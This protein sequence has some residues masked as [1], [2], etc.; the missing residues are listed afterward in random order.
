M[1]QDPLEYRTVP[2]TPSP[3]HLGCSF[4]RGEVL[5]IQE[6]LQAQEPP[7]YNVAFPR[8][9]VT[10]ALRTLN[11]MVRQEILTAPRE[12]WRPGLQ[13]R[14]EG[15]GVTAAGRMV[16]GHSGFSKTSLTIR[17]LV[18]RS[19]AVRL[20]H[21]SVPQKPAGTRLPHRPHSLRGAN[22]AETHLRYAVK[23]LEVSGLPQWG[24][25]TS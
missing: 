9:A 21:V 18:S 20:T 10:C 5:W 24:L 13:C 16:L 25:L 4:G 6:P 2:C 8:P 11:R 3:A 22:S 12:R 15:G 1:E 17:V 14:A 19:I 23:L 7:R